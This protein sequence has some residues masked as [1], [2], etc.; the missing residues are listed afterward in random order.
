[1][2]EI[3]IGRMVLSMCQTNCYFLYRDGEKDCIVID[4]ADKGNQIYGTLQKNG[5]C[6]IWKALLIICTCQQL[7]NGPMVLVK[8]L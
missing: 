8:M 3:K 5:F 2:S 6:V 7:Q 1:M 4:P